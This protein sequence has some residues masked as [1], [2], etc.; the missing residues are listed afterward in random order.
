[1]IGH[2]SGC[3]SLRFPSFRDPA[4]APLE[5]LE[6]CWL[7][8]VR[9]GLAKRLRSKDIDLGQTVGAPEYRDSALRRA[10][11]RKTK[12]G[13]TGEFDHPV[14]ETIDEHHPG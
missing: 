8:I 1:M 11:Y 3:K 13:A 2:E 12:R 14:F 7:A 6:Y 10:C 9:H 5:S 4:R